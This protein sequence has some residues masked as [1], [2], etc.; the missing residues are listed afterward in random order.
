MF[1]FLTPKDVESKLSNQRLKLHHLY[2]KVRS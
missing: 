1:W 2:W